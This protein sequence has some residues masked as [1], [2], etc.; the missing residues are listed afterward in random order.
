MIAYVL[1]L[2]SFPNIRCWGKFF[3]FDSRMG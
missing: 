1:I 3:S 2:T